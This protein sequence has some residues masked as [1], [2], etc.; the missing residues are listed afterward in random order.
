[1]EHHPTEH[2]DHILDQTGPEQIDDYL[3]KYSDD[4]AKEN[5]AFSVYMK[6]LI[7][8]KGFTQQEVFDRADMSYHYGYRLL[9]QEKR[10]IRRDY[11]LR[12]CFAA[13]FSLKEA[14]RSLKLY[15]MNE[16]YSRIPRDAVMIIAFNQGIYDIARVNDMLTAHDFEPLQ[17]GSSSDR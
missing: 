15:G 2:L 4:L 12:L 6:K 3:D 17:S 1:M 8:D 14:Q 7:H 11:I 13:Q 5:N 16:L 10:T 9:S